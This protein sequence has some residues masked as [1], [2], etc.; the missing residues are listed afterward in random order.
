MIDKRIRKIAA[1]IS[2]N[3]KVCPKCD[4][5]QLER[6]NPFIEWDKKEAESLFSYAFYFWQRC[7][8]CNTV[9][10]ISKKDATDR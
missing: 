6:Y 5:A 1:A 4:S 2:G 3:E 8:D 7:I 10:M 9:F